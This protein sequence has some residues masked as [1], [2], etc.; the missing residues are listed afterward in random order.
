MAF[1]TIDHYTTYN[2]LFQSQVGLQFLHADV[3]N[4]EFIQ[5]SAG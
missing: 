3:K 5:A 2:F 4:E 1:L